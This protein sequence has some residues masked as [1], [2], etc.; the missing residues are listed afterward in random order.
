MEVN[1]IPGVRTME[2]LMFTSSLA[3]GIGYW[4]GRSI[5]LFNPTQAAVFCITYLVGQKVASYF[6][7]KLIKTAYPYEIYEESVS[8]RIA[9]R[10]MALGFPVAVLSIPYLGVGVGVPVACLNFAIYFMAA[11]IYHMVR[12]SPS[13]IEN[14]NK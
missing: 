10:T 7:D 1:I 2:K 3:F 13:E 9:Q 8:G 6:A 12:G 4:L 5:T 11:N 14:W